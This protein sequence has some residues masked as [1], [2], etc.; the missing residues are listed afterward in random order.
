MGSFIIG[1]DIDEAGIGE[2]IA[3]T[4]RRYGVDSLNAL[5]LTPLPGTRLWDQMKT[6]NRIALRA[7]PED[8]RY[9][10]L[11]FPVARYQRLSLDAVIKEMGDCNRTF[12]S[13]PGVLRRFFASM[14]PHRK[15]LINLVTNLS[16]RINSKTES[17]ACAA[18]Q[19]Q[20]QGSF[21]DASPEA[22]SAGSADQLAG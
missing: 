6:D 7:F 20:W 17:Q 22:F 8:W 16:A 2:R 3:E 11:A 18:F 1:L 15:P 21:G 10:T 9:Y 4:A 12:Y 13:M 14:W 5:F 19:E